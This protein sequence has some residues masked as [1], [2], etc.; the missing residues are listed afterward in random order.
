MRVAPSVSDVL[1]VLK[2]VA[3]VHSILLYEA[4]GKANTAGVFSRTTPTTRDSPDRTRQF[5][6]KRVQP[7]CCLAPHAFLR[8]GFLAP[9]SPFLLSWP[10]RVPT[11]P[12]RRAL[13]P[14]GSRSIGDAGALVV[15]VPAAQ[16]RL[17]ALPADGTR[18]HR[19]CPPRRCCCGCHPRWPLSPAPKGGCAA[20][21][22]FSSPR[23]RRRRLGGNRGSVSGGPLFSGHL[24]LARCLFISSCAAATIRSRARLAGV[25]YRWNFRCG[26][27]CWHCGAATVIAP[28]SFTPFRRSGR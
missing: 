26:R 27:L 19:L 10:P 20:R 25:T 17:D 9:P 23:R 6:G 4:Q 24:L 1:T 13:A 21:R 14:T 7:P 28:R 3:N 22:Y 16:V 8:R 18:R 11:D 5:R 2:T 15:K 12:S